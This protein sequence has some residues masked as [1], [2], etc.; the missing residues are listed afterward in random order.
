M[1]DSKKL[2]EMFNCYFENK[3][4]KDLECKE[5]EKELENYEGDNFEEELSALY[6]KC[7]DTILNAKRTR[8]RY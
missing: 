6:K 1:S 2:Q 8:K 5:K 3:E 7:D 4:A